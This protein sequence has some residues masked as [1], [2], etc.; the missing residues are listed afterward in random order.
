[1]LSQ[2]DWTRCV[3]GTDGGEKKKP[4][5]NWIGVVGFHQITQQSKF[6]DHT[7][8]FRIL[9]RE[10]FVLDTSSFIKNRKFQNWWVFLNLHFTKFLPKLNLFSIWPQTI[11]T[12]FIVFWN[13][14]LRWQPGKTVCSSS[15]SYL[16]TLVFSV[17][18]ISVK[19][20]MLAIWQFFFLSHRLLLWEVGNGRKRANFGFFF[21]FWFC[22]RWI[23]FKNGV[24]SQEGDWNWV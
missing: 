24:G 21:L 3:A 17:T 5:P 4:E 7:M 2:A 13:I 9:S 19:A 22:G 16:R 1:M 11:Q 20:L 12:I 10:N 8:L 14:S 6:F 23:S 18:V 15:K